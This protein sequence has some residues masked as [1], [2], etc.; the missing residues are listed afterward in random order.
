MRTYY[1]GDIVKATV[2]N[3]YPFGIFVRLE[4]NNRAY[5]RIREL[6]LSADI[7]PRNVVSIGDKIEAV[8]SKPAKSGRVMELSVRESLPDPWVPFIKQVHIGDVIKGKVKNIFP[9]RAYIETTPGV[10]GFIMRDQLSL[11]KT[12]RIEDILWTGDHI[13]AV[14]ISIDQRKKKLELSLRH[15]IIQLRDAQ[16]YLEQ[17]RVKQNEP[18]KT[19]NLESFQD[20]DVKTNR[21]FF[22][23]SVLV[24]EDRAEVREPLI[25]WLI[26]QG[27][28]AVGAGRVD[29]ALELH[30]Q[31]NFDLAIVDIDIPILSGLSFIEQLRSRNNNMTVAVMS[32]PE[33][34]ATNSA[35]LQELRVAGVFPKPLDVDEILQFLGH[36]TSGEDTQ[37]RFE[38]QDKKIFDIVQPYR[39]MSEAMR[40]NHPIIERFKEGL[41]HL[42]QETKADEAIVFYLD[43]NSKRIYIITSCGSLSINE[44]AVYSL[45]NS[46]VNDVITRQ[47]II[48]ENN[49]YPQNHKRF[50]K[51]T[52]MLNFRSCI[53]FPISSGG[54]IEHAIFIFHHLADVFD[55]NCL[56]DVIS[57]A[58]Y[59]SI[60]LENQL[61][62]ERVQSLGS[63]F[64][65]GQLAAGF[66]HEIYNKVSGLDLQFRNIRFD[67]SKIKENQTS[68]YLDFIK[69]NNII[70]NTLNLSEDLKRTVKEFRRLMEVRKE[71]RSDINNAL[72][73]TLLQVQPYA[74]KANINI[75]FDNN[76]ELPFIAGNSLSILQI[77]L[78]VALNAIQQMEQQK[79]SKGE[80]AISC[81]LEEEKVVIR[82]RDSGPGIHRRLWEK[83]FDLGFTTRSGGSGIGLFI[84]R[85]L[86]E[87]LGGKI[88][89][90]E[91][92][93]ALGTTFKIELL[94]YGNGYQI[95]V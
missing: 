39:N 30:S 85:N 74:T 71:D 86:T 84:A 37:F 78:N 12:E 73:Q 68:E 9:N 29:Q 80:L 61:L 77:F 59:F 33:L 26:D 5:I 87:S 72:N 3:I 21:N 45:A 46:P 91:S 49:L 88:L 82:F 11:L 58:M 47:S 67:M 60:A 44:D 50:E 16:T 6:T 22:P 75:V 56:R 62:N 69:I 70:E 83:I 38:I 8:I 7:D 19:A 14:I 55:Q 79:E 23:L 34:I 24:V 13:E 92:L 43:D 94:C 40:S 20:D 53:G 66:A 76:N 32:D 1:T 15:R 31:N 10:F 41:E 54:K 51:L 65:S 52:T 27:C 17:L 95:P 90:E 18:E 48:W 4:D 89:V 63:L 93:I 25:H 28:Q 64:L 81:Q 42:L 36:L 35:Y 2:E 57:M